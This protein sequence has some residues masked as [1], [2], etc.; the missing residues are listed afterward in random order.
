M[1]KHTKAVLATLVMTLFA[2]GSLPTNKTASNTSVNV[3]PQLPA[4]SSND[5]PSDA[6]TKPSMPNLKGLDAETKNQFTKLVEEHRLAMSAWQAERDTIP[7]LE[8]K[9][10]DV[11][12]KAEQELSQRPET[13]AFEEREWASEDGK[14]KVTATLLDSDF[15]VAKLKKLDGSIVEVSK[16]KLSAADKQAIERA[17]AVL[18]VAARREKEWIGRL[19]VLEDEKKEIQGLLDEANKPAP[20]PPTVDQAKLLVEE[21]RN[22]R[23]AEKLKQEVEESEK[24]GKIHPSQIEVLETRVVERLNAKG[25]PM[26]MIECKFQNNSRRTVRI[27]DCTYTAYDEGG[28]KVFDRPY[29]L[30]AVD[31]SN[32]GIPAGE[33]QDT[34]RQGLFIP[35]KL[36]VKSAK[37][38]ITKVL[39]RDDSKVGKD[40]E[41]ANDS[42]VVQFITLIRFQTEGKFIT[43]VG[44]KGETIVVTVANE[45][46]F[47]PYQ[48]RLQM[49]QNIWTTWVLATKAENP[50]HAR[51]DIKDL[52]GNSVGGSRLLGGSLSWVSK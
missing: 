32:K 15:K 17:F 18:E 29:T 37:V 16:E 11:E 41:G 36:G 22:N 5:E 31:D 49:A 9:K 50:D 24:N 19:A 46:H 44:R 43:Q 23:D 34:L 25:E 27:I 30:Y 47:L 45:W 28:K 21:M 51:V 42:H 52:N 26:D 8:S 40:G 48:I 33:W 38:V 7:G 6:A 14:Y 35:K 39:E 4:P 13:P 2:F 10:K 12:A 20:E 3:S 1:N